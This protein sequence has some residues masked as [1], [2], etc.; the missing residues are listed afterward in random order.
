MTSKLVVNTIEADTG[1]SSVSFASSIS[2]SSTSKFHFSDAGIDIG[3]DTNINRP[4][5]GVIGFNINS[6]EKVRITSDGVLKL[7][8]QS[9]S[10]ETAGLTYHTNGNLYIRGGTTGAVLQSVDSN[11][12]WIVQNDYISG[13]TGG[14]ER[15]RITSA[16]RIGIGTETPDS[17]LAIEGTG[18]DNNTRISIKDGS[19]KVNVV[20]RYGNLS[21]QADEGNAVSGSLMQFKVDG[22]ERLRISANG[23]VNIGGDFTSTS[24]SLQIFGS[25]GTNSASLGIKNDTSGPAGIHLLSGHGN[26]SIFNSWSVGDALEFRDESAGAI[27][28]MIDSS[29]RFIVGHN[30]NINIAGH[31]SAFLLTG[32]TYN[33]H[34]AAIIAN[35][36]TARGA[37]LQFA[38]QRSGSAGGNTIVQ[39]GD[40]IGHMRFV[41]CD[42]VDLNSRVAEITAQVDGTPG[43]NSTPGRLIFRTTPSNSDNALERLRI[44]KDGHVTKPYQPSFRAGLNSNTTVS[45]SS[46]IVF[47]DTGATWHHNIGNHYNTSNG[48]F[49]APVD[50]VYSFDAC[51]IFGPSVTNNIFMGDAFLYD[52]NGGYAAYSGRRG[53]Y[54]FGSTGNS[55]YV[56]HMS[57]RFD[58]SAGDYVQIRNGSPFTAVHGNTYYTWFAGTL[59]G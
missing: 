13:S 5:T 47:N 59:L 23:N 33:Q 35:E 40:N 41:A 29:G 50:G 16:G 21:L 27:R 39:N 25:G 55:Y 22:D 24:Y 38:K 30:S 32:D 8:G 20:G 7:T 52:I 57:C 4:A 34:T 1:I 54:V 28:A 31:S 37:M 18:S 51:V 6:G 43:S 2:M 10:L 12:A 58:L 26:W 36:N 44:N 14:L 46:H 42:G 19:G 3:A 49:T 53:Y 48:R 15:L 56:D 45:S 17:I 9:S 11:E